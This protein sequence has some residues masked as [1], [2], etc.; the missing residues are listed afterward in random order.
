MDQPYGYLVAVVI[1]ASAT[2]FAL[3]PFRGRALAMMS[4]RCSLIVYE[5]PVL[6]ACWLAVV[7]V[8]TAL[9]DGLGNP[10]GVVGAALASLTC[11]VLAV[12]ARRGLR[13]G[14]AVD[15][16]MSGAFGP[17][18]RSV[19]PAGRPSALAGLVLPLRVRRRGVVRVADLSYGPAG[20]RNRLDVLH[21]RDLPKGGPVLVHFHGG[22]Y[23]SGRKNREARQL[24]HRLAAHG[25]VCLSAN[26]RLRPSAGFAEHVADAEAA[27]AWARE[28]APGY[29]AD[30]S[31]LFLAGGS[32][33]AH[34]AAS[35]ALGGVPVR[36]VVCLYGYY[37]RYYE[38]G[39]GSS[40]LDRLRADAPPFLVAHGDRDSLVPVE[41]AREF[42]GRLRAASG[43]P[44]VFAELPGGQHA[45]DLFASPRSCA[46]AEAVE[47][48]ALLVRT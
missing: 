18:W 44:V 29:G 48:F 22:G 2:V 33:G 28:H 40:P 14:P 6:A 41:A 34:L 1:V 5:L 8:W 38:T 36:G 7:T 13:T 39:A 32:A 45:F 26:Y 46:V 42:A 3:V 9:D 47:A 43:G 27:V 25:W 20:K 4:F 21:R 15:A 31:A 19:L 23:F 24:L 16:A 11:L 37:G 30:P 17:R 10:V 35:I 12:I